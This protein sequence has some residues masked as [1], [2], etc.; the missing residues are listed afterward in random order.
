MKKHTVTL[1]AFNGHGTRVQATETFED[2]YSP[3]GKQISIWEFEFTDFDIALEFYK[4]V[5]EFA[6]DTINLTSK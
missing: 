2:N 3:C 5:M 1:G 6:D 4:I